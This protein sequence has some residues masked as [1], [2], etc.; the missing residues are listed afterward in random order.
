MMRTA[1]ALLI[2][3]ALTLGAAKHAPPRKPAAR[4]AAGS[5][6]GTWTVVSSQMAANMLT[7]QF[8]VPVPLTMT[9]TD[10]SSVKGDRATGNFKEKRIELF[11]H[12]EVHDL[13]GSFGLQSASQ[14]QGKGPATLTSDQL[15]VND[16]THFYDAGGNVHYEQ[17]ATKVDA[18]SAQLN[19]LTHVLTLKGAVHVVDAD[20]DLYADTAQF[21]TQTGDGTAEN[22]VR[23]EFPGTNAEIAT[24][25]PI[26]IK[27]PKIP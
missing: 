10:G 2:V 21:N 3:A 23:M 4:A 5:A 11:G 18:Q 22:N 9:R 7:G 20:R 25:K 16:T 1:S 27:G 6:V 12:V 17:G 19:D 15:N 26:V 8:S 24:P 14:A 13:S